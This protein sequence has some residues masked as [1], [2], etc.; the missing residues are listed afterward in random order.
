MIVKMC[1]FTRPED[2]ALAGK[3]GA[4][5]VGVILVR[6]SPRSISVS[7]AGEVFNAA[8][9]DVI[10]VVVMMPEDLVHAVKV[11]RELK[12]DYIQLHYMVQ[13]G[14]MEEIRDK[15]GFRMIGVVAV[16]ET[17]AEFESLAE[18]AG[19]VSDICDMVLIDTKG[20]HGGG[21]G[22]I[23]DWDLSA[24]LRKLLRKPVLLAGGLTP[25]NV[26]TAI[27]AV[28]PDGV[29]VATGI[30]SS[31]GIKDPGRMRDFMK[32]VETASGSEKCADDG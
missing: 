1:G 5:M 21:T 16:P 10:K 15:T 7:R 24:R 25:E 23:H 13:P 29:D 31:P 27:R 11:G 22:K 3:I 12:P 17:G 20:P 4:D 8:G 30:E 6:G 14:I 28:R 2:A 32:A 9:N 18:R 26:C 19:A